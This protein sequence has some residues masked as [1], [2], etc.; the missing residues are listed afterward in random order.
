MKDRGLYIANLTAFKNG[1]LDSAAIHAHTEFLIEAGVS[2]LCPAGTTGEFLYLT[3]SEKKELF[4]TIIAAAG[5]RAKVLCCP[6]DSDAE[7]MASLCRF[8]SDKGADGIFL[9]PPIYY[10]FTDE[11]IFGFYA[12]ARKHSGVPIYCYNI[13]KYS[14]NE[15]SIDALTVLHERNVIV[16]IKDSCANEERIAEISARFGESLELFAGGDHFVLKAKSLG[17]NGFISALGNVYPESF[18]V[19]WNTPTE[20]LQEEICKL[21]NGIKGYGSIPAM[22]YLLSKRGHRF[23]CRFPFREVDNAHKRSLDALAQLK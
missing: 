6:W 15:I 3:A 20:E 19:L 5:G 21:R 8:V 22:K 16:G 18:V 4:F 1:L 12:F 7:T 23:G 14:N 2:G 17:A 13:P 9:P 11:E 10:R